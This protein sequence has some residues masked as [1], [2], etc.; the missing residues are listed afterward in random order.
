MTRSCR[1]RRRDRRIG[2]ERFKFVVEANALGDQEL[3]ELLHRRGVHRE[4]LD[5]WRVAIDA[6]FAS[7]GPSHRSPE[8]KRIKQLERED[9]ALAE[10]A[11]L[12][13]LQKNFISCSRRIRT[14]RTTTRTTGAT[15][16]PRAHRRGGDRWCGGGTRL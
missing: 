12:L 16:D 6:A 13:V 2:G 5:A 15:S 9:K 10:F 4:Q 8:G 11:A 14:P 3:G 7:T 1:T